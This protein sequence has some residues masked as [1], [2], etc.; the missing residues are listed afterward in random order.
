MIRDF[1]DF[2]GYPAVPWSIRKNGR[3]HSNGET[4]LTSPPPVLGKAG[5]N[6]GGG[7]SVRPQQPPKSTAQNR[8][9]PRKRGDVMSRAR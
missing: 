9:A 2:A 6:N 4:A 3:L 1:E 8:A 5:Q 7:P